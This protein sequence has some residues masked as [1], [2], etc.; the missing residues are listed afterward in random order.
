MGMA[1]SNVI[2]LVMNDKTLSQR[3]AAVAAD[4]SRVILTG[5][6]KKRMRERKIL[7]TQVLKVLQRGLVVEPAHR[8]IYGNWKCT[9]DLSIA[10]D[11]IKVVAALVGVA[12][13]ETVVVITIMN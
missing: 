7:F 9:L 6:A 11:H 10:G 8:D 12:P 4:S 3:M 5:H 13:R 1:E 2:P